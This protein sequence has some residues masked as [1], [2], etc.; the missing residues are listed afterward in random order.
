MPDNEAD[1]PRHLAADT[2]AEALS[3]TPVGDEPTVNEPEPPAANADASEA[4]DGGTS[5]PMTW[6]EVGRDFIRPG[7]GQ[8]VLAAI[9]LV[10]GMALVMQYRTS[11]TQAP[12]E[13]M[14]RTDL[15]QLLDNL[16]QETQ[17]LSTEISEQEDLQRQLQSGV[18]TE[19]VARAEA[20][21]RLDSLQIL[22]G[23]AP[24]TGPGITLVIH[25]PQ[26]KMT[27]DTLLN[28]IEELRDAGAEVIEINNSIRVVASTWIASGTDG[29]LVDGT[30]VKTPITI[31][32]IGEPHALEEGARFRGGLV[33]EVEGQRVGGSVTITQSQKLTISSL[34][35]APTNQY[36]RPA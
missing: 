34:H 16:N 31:K 14:R 25:D 9:M 30:L 18:G 19:E 7:R 27:A 20:Q 3:G 26:N 36:A 2:D 23:T 35:K 28:S 12:Y 33:S 4:D 8:I 5:S 11:T 32:A 15:V 6:R 10:V 17:R 22:A 21:R 13:N 1:H 29:I 24:A